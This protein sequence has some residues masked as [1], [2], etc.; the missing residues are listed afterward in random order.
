[1]N[2]EELKEFVYSAPFDVMTEVYRNEDVILSVYRP[3]KLKKQF[4]GYD[5]SK[6]LQI[7]MQEGANQPF[8]PNHLRVLIDL[9]LRVMQKP[10]LRKP[11]LKAFDN[12]F[13]GMDPDQA[14]ASLKKN[15]FNICLNSIDV[16]AHLA[17]LMI[18]EQNEGFGK[19]SKYDPMSLYVQ[20]WIRAF[21]NEPR[22]IDYIIKR[23]TDS[24]HGNPPPAQ[25]YT[26]KDNKKH[27][28]YD[29]NVK[30]L[31]YL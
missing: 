25:K 20:G 2:Y 5:V 4:E 1:M 12:I 23:I 21:L 30:P 15:K 22:S 11:L 8:K 3:S 16:I 7:F 27:D 9:K 28:K 24:T 29:P 6:N 13:Y 19:V 17:Q 18:L 26:S 14:I 10:R 31:W